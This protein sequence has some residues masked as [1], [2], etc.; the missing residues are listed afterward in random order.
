MNSK[1]YFTK[2]LGTSLRDTII[3]M[4][5]RRRHVHQRAGCAHKADD[6]PRHDIA[7]MQTALDAQQ[8][9]L[10]AQFNAMESQMGQLQDQGNYLTQQFA[11]MNKSS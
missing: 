5:L 1:V 10:Y 8:Q 9:K 2:G 11:A 3:G 7:N 6:R 4:T